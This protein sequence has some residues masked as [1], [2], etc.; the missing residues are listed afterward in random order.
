MYAELADLSRT[1]LHHLTLGLLSMARVRYAGAARQFMCAYRM[2]RG[3]V[4]GLL[5]TRST[6]RS[7]LHVQML[8][9]E[10]AE[11]SA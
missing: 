8:A 7:Q 11:N 3:E 1:P 2:D 5:C 10:L 4:A 6:P 9:S